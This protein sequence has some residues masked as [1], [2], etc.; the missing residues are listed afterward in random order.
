MKV[1]IY[2]ANITLTYGGENMNVFNQ[3]EQLINYC[4]QFPRF[5]AAVYLRNRNTFEELIQYLN[6]GVIQSYLRNGMIK[7][8]KCEYCI[9]FDNDSLFYI[10]CTQSNMRGRR[11][12]MIIVDEEIP[13]AELDYVYLPMITPYYNAENLRIPLIPLVYGNFN[14]LKT[15]FNEYI[16]E[17]NIM[18]TVCTGTGYYF[19]NG[20]SITQYSLPIK[21]FDKDNKHILLYGAAGIDTFEYHADFVNKTKETFLVIKGECDWYEGEY[22]NEVN[23]RLKIDTNIYDGYSVAWND[24]IL[25]VELKEIINEK[26][27]FAEFN[28]F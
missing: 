12:N 25:V 7:Y 26:P 20:K 11:C 18:A 13:S 17:N 15:D 24:G 1:W 14:N 2:S 8:T 19:E 9:L 3:I 23:I 10:N 27:K 4:K 5:R 16:K 22:E 28:S 21:E 6:K